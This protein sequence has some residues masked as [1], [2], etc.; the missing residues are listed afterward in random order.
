MIDDVEG[1]DAEAGELLVVAAFAVAG[2]KMS[3]DIV[4]VLDARV[5]NYF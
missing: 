5:L 2:G 3:R 1:E 4:F